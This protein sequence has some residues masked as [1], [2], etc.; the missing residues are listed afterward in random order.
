MQ[1]MKVEYL[2]GKFSKM[3]D[4]LRRHEGKFLLKVLTRKNKFYNR[5]IRTNKQTA[6]QRSPK[7]YIR[8]L[9]ISASVHEQLKLPRS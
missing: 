2:H 3:E 5:G 1:A 4:D 7:A 9:K 8:S 6:K